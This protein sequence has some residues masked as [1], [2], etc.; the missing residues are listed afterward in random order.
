MSGLF[1]F[2]PGVFRECRERNIPQLLHVAF[3]FASSGD[4][5]PRYDLVH[6]IWL[7]S[8]TKRLARGIEC[9][10]HNLGGGVVE[11]ASRDERK[12]RCHAT[13]PR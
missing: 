13:S 12:D 10:A 1:F 11:N 8:V 3:A 4:D 2:C 9:L 7:A 6:D 5:S